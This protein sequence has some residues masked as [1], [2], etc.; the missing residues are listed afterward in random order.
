MVLYCD[1]EK[2]IFEMNDIYGQKMWGLVRAQLWWNVRE[3]HSEDKTCQRT[4]SIL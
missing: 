4:Q 3:N 1:G 2:T